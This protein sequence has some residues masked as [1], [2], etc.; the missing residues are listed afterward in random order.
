MSSVHYIF[1]SITREG[2]NSHWSNQYKDRLQQD[3]HQVQLLQRWLADVYTLFVTFRCAV[4]SFCLWHWAHK[5]TLFDYFRATP[6]V[7]YVSRFCSEFTNH[8]VKLQTCLQP[9]ELIQES[10]CFLLLAI[11]GRWWILS[12]EGRAS[13]RYNDRG[14]RLDCVESVDLFAA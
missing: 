2:L 6:T 5:L 9:K 14:E 3:Q 11:P 4:S 7:R 1:A 10:P 12:E 13:I 8:S